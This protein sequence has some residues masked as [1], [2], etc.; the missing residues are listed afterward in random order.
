MDDVGRSDVV[1]AH[2][3][4]EVGL[5]GAFR[6]VRDGREVTPAGMPGQ[7]LRLVAMRAE[8]VHL[9]DVADALWPEAAPDH[10]RR[11]IRNVLAR[12]RDACGE[13]VERRGDC[14]LLAPGVR[15]DLDAFTEAADDAI[16]GLRD[17]VGDAARAARAALAMV[18]QELLPEDRYA[19]WAADVRGRHHRRVLE[20]LDRLAQA[21]VAD[22]DRRE[23]VRLLLEAIDLEPYDEERYVRAAR[24]MAAD[25]RRGLAAHLLDIATM[26]LD[27]L[28]VVPSPSLRRLQ[29]LVADPTATERVGDPT[30]QA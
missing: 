14:L 17:G 6:V 8:P 2:P 26:M 30:G 4:A 28:G 19:L 10:G 3:T 29:E 22:G 7:L 5:I 18:R 25:G 23:A 15:V 21:A 12:L 16:A 1:H 13:V 9:D 20:L 11:R 24:L 27:D